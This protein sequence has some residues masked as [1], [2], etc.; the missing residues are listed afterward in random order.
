VWYRLI[1]VAVLSVFWLICVSCQQKTNGGRSSN[2][3]SSLATADTV[4]TINAVNSSFRQPVKDLS[5]V[6]QKKFVRITANE[7]IN[8]SELPISFDLYFISGNETVFLG[9]VA[10]FPASNPGS[11]IIATGGKVNK[12][13][14][15][16]LRLK[17]PDN[18]NKNDRVE[19]KMKRLEFE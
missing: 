5:T 8:S 2:N 16:E 7:I 3:A 1:F 14:E 19:V 10:P 6:R 18:R 15:L 12:E 11:Y 13:G 9:S 17:L 4:Y